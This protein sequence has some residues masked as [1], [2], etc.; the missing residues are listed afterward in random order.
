MNENVYWVVENGGGNRESADLIKKILKKKDIPFRDIGMSFFWS[1]EKD[2]DNIF[3]LLKGITDI[4]LA[5]RLSFSVTFSSV[6]FSSKIFLSKI[7]IF[8][9][10]LSSISIIT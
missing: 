7:N 1:K 2:T 9:C 4:I 3:F 5:S 6:T 10:L 8:P